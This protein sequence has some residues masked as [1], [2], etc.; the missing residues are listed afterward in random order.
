MAKTP[1][2]R[3]HKRW[4]SRQSRDPQQRIAADSEIGE[5]AHLGQAGDLHLAHRSTVLAPAEDLLDSLAQPLARPVTGV[6]RRAPIERGAALA[7]VVRGHVRGDIALAQGG[8][9]VGGVVSLVGGERSPDSRRQPIEHRECRLTFSEA[10]CFGHLDIHRQAGA[11]LHQHM[12]ET[13]DGRALNEMKIELRSHNLAFPS[14]GQQTTKSSSPAQLAQWFIAD[15]RKQDRDDLQVIDV[16]DGEQLA[17][18][19]A[20]RVHFSYRLPAVVGSARIEH[21]TIGA[22]VPRGL[23][24]AQLDAPQLGY[25]AKVLPAFQESVGTIELRPRRHLH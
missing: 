8:D 24:L 3:G 2:L 10:V 19:P 6:T 14:S 5:E 25:F 23:L 16:S 12:P 17:G 1:R 21:V 18:R 15:L 22:A 7:A 20:F 9:E 13:R 11:V 4:W